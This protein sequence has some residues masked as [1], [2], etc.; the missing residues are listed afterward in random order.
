[1]T[2]R[3]TREIIAIGAPFLGCA[4]IGVGILAGLVGCSSAEENF[5]CPTVDPQGGNPAGSYGLSSSCAATYDRV[6]SGDW[7][8]QLVLDANGI[9]MAVL[10]HGALAA[11]N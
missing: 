10:G 8:S 4:L 6:Q 7:C 2:R 5:G 11:V 1:M 9:R 3:S